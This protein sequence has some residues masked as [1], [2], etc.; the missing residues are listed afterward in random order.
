MYPAILSND[1]EEIAVPYMEKDIN[2]QKTIAQNITSRINE[3]NDK[4]K[5]AKN[6]LQNTKRKVEETIAKIL[7]TK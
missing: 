3:I 6:I 7:E 1:L 4:R 5:T 2:V